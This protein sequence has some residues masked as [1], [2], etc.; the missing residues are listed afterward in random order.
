MRNGKTVSRPDGELQPDTKLAESSPLAYGGIDAAKAVAEGILAMSQ[1]AAH[2][3][4]YLHHLNGRLALAWADSLGGLKDDFERADDV[5]GLFSIPAHMAI[6]QL[7]Q[8][9]RQFVVELQELARAQST[10]MQDGTCTAA[11]Q[12]NQVLTN[13]P[14]MP[15]AA[16]AGEMSPLSALGGVRDQWLAMTRGWIDAVQGHAAHGTDS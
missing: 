2:G 9:A 4:E 1:T 11:S 14:G 7:E 5:A 16:A 8:M 10:W 13:L 12:I 6:R 15:K 3:L